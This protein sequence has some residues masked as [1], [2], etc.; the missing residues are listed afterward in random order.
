[1]GKAPCL[2][3]LR[4]HSERMRPALASDPREH[5]SAGLDQ[6]NLATLHQ[7]FPPRMLPSAMAV[8]L[9][10]GEKQSSNRFPED[11]GDIDDA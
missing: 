8:G 3:G 5:L 1:M 7:S 2:R 4:V 9:D 10:R 6:Q 11:F